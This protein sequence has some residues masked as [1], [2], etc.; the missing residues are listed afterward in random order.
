MRSRSVPTIGTTFIPFKWSHLRTSSGHVV[1]ATRSGAITSAG[2]S[3]TICRISSADR[4]ATVLP[5]PMPA[6]TA[7]RLPSRMWLMISVWYGRG[8]NF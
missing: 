4:V 3:S 5:V 6:H 7:T 1:V 2:P 8:V